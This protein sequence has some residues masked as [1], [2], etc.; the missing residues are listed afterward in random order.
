MNGSV[1]SPPRDGLKGQEKERYS[2]SKG[3]RLRAIFSVLAVS[4]ASLALAGTAGAQGGGGGVVIQSRDACD[5][6]TFPPGL[7]AR[8]DNSGGVV[9][10][11]ELLA[12]LQQKQSHPAWRFTEDKVDVKRGAPVVA[13]FGRGGEVHSFTDVTA[14]GFG[15]GCVDVINLAMFGSPATNPL[16]GPDPLA[17]LGAIL[18]SPDHPNSGLFPGVPITID[19]STPGTRLFQCMLHPWMRTTV[20]VE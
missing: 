3:T 20:T 16:C 14:S 10:I 15:P 19:T 6:A 8:T 1:P 2:M 5:P 17:G 13:E 9:T 12:R 7:C 4:A 18:G 11:N